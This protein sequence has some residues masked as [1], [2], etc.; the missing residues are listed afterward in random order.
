[1][2]LAY[3][4]FSFKEQEK[5]SVE[6]MLRS[7]ILQIIQQDETAFARFKAYYLFDKTVTTAFNAS[8]KEML[9]MPHD[10]VQAASCSYLF[11]DGLDEC[12]DVPRLMILL[13]EFEAISE[14]CQNK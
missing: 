4:F 14:S 1:M 2:T 10:M 5:Q 7:P 6:Q 13:N 9:T 8:E 11:I 3:F 12:M